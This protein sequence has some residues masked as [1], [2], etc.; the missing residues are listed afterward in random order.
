MESMRRVIPLGPVL[1]LCVAAA[2]CAQSDQAPT[3]IPVPLAPPSAID[4]FS[5][6]LKVLA[7]I[8][9]SSN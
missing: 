2:G 8:T 1:A 9:I 3:P 6:T 7:A 5:G 4:N